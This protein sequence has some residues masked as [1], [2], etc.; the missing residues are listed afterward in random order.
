MLMVSTT[1][2]NID[3]GWQTQ[4]IELP[5]PTL[6]SMAA[7]VQNRVY[8]FGGSYEERDRKKG[9]S[10]ANSFGIIK[11]FG[12][13]F[14]LIFFFFRGVNPLKDTSGPVGSIIYADL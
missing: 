1:L 2:S 7:V 6:Y 13:R 4:S 14:L 3:S 10:L 12:K 11:Y 9:N 8:V 5:F